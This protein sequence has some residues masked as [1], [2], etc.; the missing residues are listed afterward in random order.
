[1]A[2]KLNIY[3][4]DTDSV[5]PSLASC[6]DA[7]GF[8][9]SLSDLAW[10]IARGETVCGHALECPELSSGLGGRSGEQLVLLQGWLGTVFD[11][12]TRADLPLRERVTCANPENGAIRLKRALNAPELRD[13]AA[14]YREYLD[15]ADEVD[16]L[17]PFLYDETLPQRGSYLRVSSAH[18]VYRRVG[19][20]PDPFFYTYNHLRDALTPKGTYA[21]GLGTKHPHGL[22]SEQV[23]RLPQLLERPVVLMDSDRDNTMVAV[24]CDVDGD[25]LPLIAAIRPGCTAVSDGHRIPATIVCS[26]YGKP[27][28]YF[29]H[30]MLERPERIIYRD[31]EK[32][33]ELDARAKLQLFGGHIVGHDLNREIIRVPACIVNLQKNAKTSAPAD[34]RRLARE[35]KDLSAASR[36]HAERKGAKPDASRTD[37]NR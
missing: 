27:A 22:T 25:G 29:V 26:F 4:K 8:N 15:Y 17:A 23:C 31:I 24:L 20:S 34:G 19:F 16:A 37:G 32:G 3:C 33:R 11:Y 12:E 7:V 18:E 5:Y 14:R 13:L 35:S 36:A 6:A 28:G 1:M 10:R 21:P 9:G 2:G 30:K